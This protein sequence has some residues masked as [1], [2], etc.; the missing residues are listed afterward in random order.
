MS[1]GAKKHNILMRSRITEKSNML[2]GKGVYCFHVGRDANKHEI[3]DAVKTL[4]GV[5]P[6]TIR[7]VPVPGKKIMYRGRP[8][9]SGG[10]KKAYVYLKKGDKIEFV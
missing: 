6:I 7:I 3:R 5:T 8:G 1:T 10:S 4:Y 9:V 2:T